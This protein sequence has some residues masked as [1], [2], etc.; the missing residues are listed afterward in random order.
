MKQLK[1]RFK[2]ILCVLYVCVATAVFSQN[3]SFD[4]LDGF[5]E[6]AMQDWG[7]PGVAIGIVRNDSVLLAKGFGVKKL[8]SKEKVDAHTLF[9]VASN[10]KA[11]TA[12]LIGMLV[13]EGK[14]TWDDRVVE[15][16]NNFQMFDPYVTREINLRDLMTHRSGLPVFGGDRLWIGGGKSRE[17]IVH[18]VRYLQ[19]SAPFRTK[20]Q[21]NNLMWLVAGQVYAAVTGHSWDDGIKQRIFSPLGMGESNTSTN[22]LKN[23]FAIPHE[24]IDGKIRPIDYDNVDTV[25]PAASI[26]SNVLDMMKWMRLNLSNGTFEGTQILS[27]RVSAEMQ[28]IQIPNNISSFNREKLN[29]RFSGY[30][31]GY[32]IQEFKGYKMVRHSGGLSGMISLQVLIPKK[33]IGI[34]VLSNRAPNSLPWVISYTILDQMLGFTQTDWNAEYLT[35]KE[36]SKKAREVKREQLLVERAHET[37][38]SLKLSDYVGDY[39]EDFSGTAKVEM[40]DNRLQFN[41]KPRYIADL[42]HWHFNTFRVKWRNPIFDMPAESFA[43]FK[44]DEKGTVSE[45]TITFYQ[46]IT[47]VKK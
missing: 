13:D 7:T 20:Y 6:H 39:F 24:S 45:V 25:G 41:Y 46:P 43:T 42:E 35:L 28:S 2:T 29:M 17:H 4:N 14:L 9:A 15:H 5:I 26:N 32:G 10:S 27:R 12:A 11:F 47:F 3:S 23:N 22:Q 31:L 44:L 18:Q 8:G 16:L 34:I 21:Y 19:P 40:Q 38:P 30:G 37:Q 36:K 33:N 1:P